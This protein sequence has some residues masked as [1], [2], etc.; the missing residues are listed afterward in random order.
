MEMLISRQLLLHYLCFQLLTHI[1]HYPLERSINLM[2]TPLHTYLTLIVESRS[3]CLLYLQIMLLT[4]SIAFEGYHLQISLLEHIAI[5]IDRIDGPSSVSLLLT[6]RGHHLYTYIQYTSSDLVYITSF[7]GDGST[8][9][10]MP[11]RTIPIKTFTQRSGGLD[12][13]RRERDT[14]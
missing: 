8:Y 2:N 6:L 7:E 3:C 12:R 9:F 11:G 10:I 4:L 1:K 5:S 14:L 13:G